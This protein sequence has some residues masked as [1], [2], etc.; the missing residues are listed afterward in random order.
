MYAQYFRDVQNI[1]DAG[2]PLN[3]FAALVAQR[4]IYLNQVVGDGGMA[5]PDQV[6]P[7]SATARL[8]A[9]AG[10]GATPF[11]RVVPGTPAN[12]RGYVNLTAGDH[13]SILSP[14][15]SPGATVE[16]QTEIVTFTASPA[17]TI[18]VTNPAVVQP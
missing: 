9:A 16:M 6:V 2:D 14:A 18:V 5:L 3:Y 11:P 12:G 4:P 1:V 15:A 10:A 13:G 17:N 7:N 8:I